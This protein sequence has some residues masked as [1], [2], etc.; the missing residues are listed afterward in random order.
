MQGEPCRE[1]LQAQA[2]ALESMIANN[3]SRRQLILKANE[4]TADLRRKEKNLAR[5]SAQIRHLELG[6]SKDDQGKGSYIQQRAESEYAQSLHKANREVSNAQVSIAELDTECA[7]L[8][9]KSQVPLL[10]APRP[11]LFTLTQSHTHILP[12]TPYHLYLLL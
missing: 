8:K 7:M 10:I 11:C 9:A 2:S 4:Q 6:M 1:A 3:R 12:Y 5:M